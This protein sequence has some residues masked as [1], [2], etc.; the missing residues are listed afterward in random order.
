MALHVAGVEEHMA[1][2]R[3]VGLHREG[4]SRELFEPREKIF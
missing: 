1:L 2:E 4:P 3:G